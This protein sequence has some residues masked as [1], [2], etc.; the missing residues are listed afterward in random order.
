MIAAFALIITICLIALANYFIFLRFYGEPFVNRFTKA[1]EAFRER[2]IQANQEMEQ[3][4]KDKLEEGEE[5]TELIEFGEIWRKRVSIIKTLNSERARLDEHIRF[6][7]FMLIF[8]L[9]HAALYIMFQRPFGVIL[10]YEVS[11]LTTGWGFTLLASSLL[12]LY[13]IFFWQL[14]LSLRKLEADIEK[15]A[16]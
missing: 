4:L 15:P 7:Y 5:P 2:M 14:E 11:A 9:M 8:S 12:I 3:R 16:P 6:L 1:Q 10:G 13:Q